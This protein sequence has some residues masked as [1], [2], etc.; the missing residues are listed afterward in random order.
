[1][2][3][4]VAR[5]SQ[6]L[7]SRRSAVVP[8]GVAQFNF[9]T[10]ESAR[11]AVIIDSDGNELIDLA[12]GL[13]AITIG[14][15]N[16]A[17]V[18]AIQCQAEQLL[19]TCIHVATYEPYLAVCEKLA[20]LLPHGRQTKVMLVNTGIEAV[21]NAIKIARQATGR[22]AV[23]VYTEGFHGRTLLGMT[24]TSKVG[25]KFGCGPF[26]PEVYRLAYPNHYRYGDGLSLPMFVEREL[27]RLRQFLVHTVHPDQVAAILIEPI[28]GEGG[29]VPAPVEYLRALR[30][31]CDEHGILLIADEVQTGF[32]RTGKW[33]AYEHAGIVPDLSVWAKAMAGGLPLGAVI[34]KAEV[35]DAASPGTLGGTFGGNPVSCAAALAAIRFMEE[36]D[37]NK[38]AETIGRHIGDRFLALQRKCPAVGDVRGVGAMMAIELVEQG[39]VHRPATALVGQVVKACLARGVLILPAGSYANVIRILAPLV[40]SDEQ[41]DRGLT[42]VEEELLRL[43]GAAVRAGRGA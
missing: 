32:C 13:G 24:L 12:G 8:R 33:A 17:V 43:A 3:T 5:K 1:M 28:Q 42:V 36:A 30:A 23:I 14:H 21:E 37:L 18:R 29:F 15:C 20:A 16:D 40:I 4:A 39:D 25:Y 26:A 19:H 6:E 2:E 7:L 34:G 38:R 27:R 41:L 31:V 9:A 11:G 35:M 10:A 22:Q